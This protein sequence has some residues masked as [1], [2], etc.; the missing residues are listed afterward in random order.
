M[1]STPIGRDSTWKY[2]RWRH[3]SGEGRGNTHSFVHAE[4]VIGRDADKKAV[5]DRLLLDSNVEDNVSI[6]PIVAIGGLGK[7][8]LA[9]L[10]FNDEQIEKHF[11]LKMWVCVSD[12]FH[13]KNIVEKIIEAATKKKP[14]A[15]EMDTLVGKL[16][17]KIDGKKYLLVLDDV[18]NEDRGKWSHLK[19]VLMGGARGSRI[20][21]TTRT[22]I[23]ARIVGTVPLYIA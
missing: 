7:T 17:E 1:P 23:V 3:E 19:Q 5:I 12:P 8:T 18:W 14:A 2:A 11:Q 15:G 13:V 21:V 9:Q 4:A 10:I 16:K 6:L 22:E 20:L